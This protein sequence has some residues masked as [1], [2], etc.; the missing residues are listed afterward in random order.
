MNRADG[1][2]EP[3]VP[4]GAALRRAEDERH[5]KTVVADLWLHSETLVR[6]ELELLK[7]E[8]E[9]R[10]GHAKA[11]VQ[12]GA[13]S[14]GLFHA[15]YLTSL[16]ALVLVLA[17]WVAPWIAALLVAF[18]ATTGALVFT[19]LSKRALAAAIETHEPQV[20][21]HLGRPQAHS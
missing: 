8:S 14:L 9:I 19:H 11:A 2:A 21:E 5:L 3:P 6:Q 15:A 18:G 13:I 16:S 7:T 4:S 1:A 20:H 10:I 12:R 17:Q